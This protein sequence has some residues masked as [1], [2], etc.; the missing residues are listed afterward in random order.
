MT[1]LTLAC[2]YSSNIS[3]CQFRNDFISEQAEQTNHTFWEMEEIF[4]ICKLV[5][6]VSRICA[7]LYVS[8]KVIVNFL[9]C[10]C[11]VFTI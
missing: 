8:F 7:S 9:Q 4:A 3:I 1:A 2:E 6:G 5:E 11:F 10:F